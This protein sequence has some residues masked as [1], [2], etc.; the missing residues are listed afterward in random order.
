MYS[1]GTLNVSN[2]ISAAFDLFFLGL[3]GASVNSTGCWVVKADVKL[4]LSLLMCITSST[5]I[6]WG[7]I[8]LVFWVDKLCGW[9]NTMRGRGWNGNGIVANNS[10]SIF[11]PYR[12]SGS[13]SH[14]LWGSECWVALDVPTHNECGNIKSCDHVTWLYK[15]LPCCR[16][17]IPLPALPPWHENALADQHYNTP[18]QPQYLKYTVVPVVAVA[19]IHSLVCK[20]NLWIL[21]SSKPSLD[22]TWPLN[23]IKKLL[24]IYPV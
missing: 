12:P 23:N 4:I 20:V 9:N 17:R 11:A 21:F 14:A 3:S 10:H 22:Y 18:R 2:I 24:L 8:K 19:C 1:A 7:W 16:R 13:L 5:Y 15:P 6:F